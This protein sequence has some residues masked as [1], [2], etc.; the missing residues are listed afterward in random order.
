MAPAPHPAPRRSICPQ[1]DGHRRR[2]NVAGSVC[3]AAAVPAL[4]RDGLDRRDAVPD[5]SR[6]RPRAS[7]EALQGAS[8]RRCEGRHADQAPG[9]GRGGFWRR[10]G[11][12][13]VRRRARRAVEDLRAA[14]RRPDRAGS[15]A[16]SHR[17]A[18][19]HGRGSDAR[20]R[21][22]TQG[23]RGTEDGKLLRIK[24]RGATRLKGSGKGDVLARIRIEVPKRVSKKQRELLEEL[25]KAS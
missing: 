5:L 6:R 20:G 3:A 1:C 7:H 4:P 9:Q 23:S 10:I 25:G 18:R 12:R 15:R 21:G 16:V 17:R 22:L 19:R 24:G 14:W 8:P 11:R 13:P 2:R